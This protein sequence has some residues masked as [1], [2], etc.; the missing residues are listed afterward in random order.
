MQTLRAT[1]AAAV[2][3]GGALAPATHAAEFHLFVRCTGTLSA[4]GK[5]KPGHL[6]L[7]LRDNNTTA[8]IARSNVLPKGERLLYTQTP[9]SYTMVYKLRQPGA[10]YHH[11]WLNGAW[12]IWQPN[13]KRLATIRLAIDRQ[14]GELEGELLDFND[15]LIGTMQMA[16]DKADPDALPEPKF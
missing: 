8:L 10:R 16:C 12:V 5:S 2:L 6:D 4:S 13:L 9:T 1:L 15:E 7:A 3:G 14:E 11:D